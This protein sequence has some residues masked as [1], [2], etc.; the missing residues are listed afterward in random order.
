MPVTVADFL[1]ELD[2][3]LRRTLASVR[4]L[5]LE[6][7]P[8]IAEGI[9]WKAP[10]FHPRG[11]TEYFATVNIHRKKGTPDCVLLVLHQGAKVKAAS[12]PAPVIR[13]PS[14]LL[15][16]LGKERAVVR[17]QG[18]RDVTTTKAALQDIIRQWVACLGH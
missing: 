6:A 9:K 16:W 14:G 17:F 3:P 4:S 8:T 2:H 18:P 15:E 1:R 5:I 12:A 10:S 13:D 11:T 7:S